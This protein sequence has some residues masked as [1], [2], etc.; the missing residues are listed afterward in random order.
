MRPA[1][2][3]DN[4]RYC[5]VTEMQPATHTWRTLHRIPQHGQSRTERLQNFLLSTVIAI[6]IALF[7]GAIVLV[8]LHLRP[9]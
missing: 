2:V 9:A 4:I 7:W 8:A 3:V 5:V 6:A 1:R